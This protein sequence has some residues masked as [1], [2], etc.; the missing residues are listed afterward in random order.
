LQSNELQKITEQLSN[1]V[2]SLVRAS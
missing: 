2:N 1:A